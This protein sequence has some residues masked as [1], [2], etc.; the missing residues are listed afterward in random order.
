[1]SVVVVVLEGDEV[2]RIFRFF[3]LVSGSEMWRRG[4]C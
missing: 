2:R 4:L 1:M 3:F